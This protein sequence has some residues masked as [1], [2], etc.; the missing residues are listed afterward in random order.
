MGEVRWCGRPAMAVKPAK[1]HL[2]IRQ[3][4]PFNLCVTGHHGTTDL[5]EGRLMK[6]RLIAALSI[7][8]TAALPL[9]A[10]ANGCGGGDDV[11]SD[12]DFVSP[13]GNIAC[14]IYADGSGANCEIQEH[15]WV[16]PASTSG[17]FGR[18]CDFDF[19]GL[20][21]YVSQGK[22]ANLGC[23]EGGGKF[24]RPGGQTLDYGQKYS[25]GSITCESEPS[26]VT[27]TDT[28]TGHFFRI[29]RESYELG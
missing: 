9:A 17:P 28:A 3:G 20:Q 29:S 27:C 24:D 8:A 22:P 10:V 7:A 16:A 4:I 12:Y 26:G 18:A 13:S 6:I 19:G 23:Y 11:P 5:R 21:I 1:N 25:R 15:N 14:S 2:R